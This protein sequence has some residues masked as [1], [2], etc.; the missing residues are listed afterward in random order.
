VSINVV[1][2][3]I[4]TVRLP[5]TL[6]A[7]M[8][9]WI[10]QSEDFTNRPDFIITALREYTLGLDII[11]NLKSLEELKR[12]KIEGF[13]ETI[14]EFGLE[15]RDLFRDELTTRI[16]QMKK[17]K[18]K[19]HSFKGEPTRVVMRM[20]L[21]L[22]KRWEKIKSLNVPVKNYQDLIRFS[23]YPFAERH[24]YTNA[25]ADPIEILKLLKDEINSLDE[26]K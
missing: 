5:S 12:L 9:R 23:I 7:D 26:K 17:D 16:E 18:E 20:P 19:Y 2:V 21:G 13:E 11:Y 25:G 24:G 8:D 15:F 14:D 3:E 10:A 1:G 22:R 6:V 4:V